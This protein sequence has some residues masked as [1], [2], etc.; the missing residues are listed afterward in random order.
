KA[1]TSQPSSAPGPRCL[2]ASPVG[3]CVGIV[4]KLAPPDLPP[5]SPLPE[6]CA[7]VVGASEPPN[8]PSGTDVPTAIAGNNDF[9]GDNYSGTCYINNLLTPLQTAAVAPS[10]S[11]APPQKIDA[12]GIAALDPTSGLLA[13]A[14]PLELIR[15]GYRVAIFEPGAT[16][17]TF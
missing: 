17:T 5:G 10:G 2:D 7:Y 11:T 15:Y 4:A 6:F 8:V 9:G 3:L 16:G 1:L 13:M 14:L 12:N